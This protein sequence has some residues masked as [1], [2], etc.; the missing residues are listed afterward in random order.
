MGNIMSEKKDWQR[1]YP[2]KRSEEHKVSRRQFATF[3]GCSALALGAGI[4]VRQALLELPEAVDPVVVANADEIIRGG[5]KLFRYPTEN[6]PC[7]LI[8]L[9]DGSFVA[10]SQS[11]THLMC[12]VH[13]DAVTSR[14]VCP[15]HNGYFD[16]ED[17]SVLAGPPQRSLPRY[18]VAVVEGKVI[19]GPGWRETA[20]SHSESV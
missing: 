16:S 12:P 2:I 3:C 9:K 8:R 7:I 13:F 14:I 1:N 20:K 11:C 6:D 18:Q 15:C 5:Y 19:V 17:G 10:Y 4:P